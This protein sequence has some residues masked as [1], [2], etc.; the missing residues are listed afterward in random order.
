LIPRGLNVGTDFAESFL[1]A[2]VFNF[3]ID[4]SGPKDVAVGND[5]ATFGVWNA[6]SLMQVDFVQRFEMFDLRG[7]IP[8]FEDGESFRCYG[9]LGARLIWMWERF[10]WRTVDSDLT[11]VA[12]PLDQARYFNIVSNRMYGVNLGCGNEWKICETPIGAFA[13]ELQVGASLLL[14]VVKE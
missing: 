11:G 14:D 10:G 13:V 5:G 8:G 7:R 4:F 6:A 9:L 1:T 2:G 12:G 3:P